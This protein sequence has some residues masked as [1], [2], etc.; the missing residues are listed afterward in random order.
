ML[1]SVRMARNATMASDDIIEL[2]TA[3]SANPA[4]PGIER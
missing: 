2:R 1:P 4:H 3:K